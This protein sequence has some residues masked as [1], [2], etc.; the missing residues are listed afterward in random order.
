[1]CLIAAQNNSFID[2]YTAQEKSCIPKDTVPPLL[3]LAGRA[4]L[5]FD[6]H[7]MW[8]SVALPVC[9]RGLHEHTNSLMFA[10]MHQKSIFFVYRNAE[11]PK[12][13]FYV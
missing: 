13:M 6:D 2:D 1:M 3:E 7:I 5:K 4:V 12:K 10:H 11:S 9:L 8:D